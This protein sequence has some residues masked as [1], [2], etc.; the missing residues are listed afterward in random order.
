M[1]QYCS[2][3][4]LDEYENQ[5]CQNI[6]L[7]LGMD[8]AEHAFQKR[9]HE[10]SIQKLELQANVLNQLSNTQKNITSEELLLGIQSMI[11]LKNYWEQQHNDSLEVIQG[12]ESD[13]RDQTES[14]KTDCQDL[15]RLEREV[16]NY[17]N[18]IKTLTKNLTQEKWY[19]HGLRI[20]ILLIGW[21]TLIY[22]SGGSTTLWDIVS[23]TLV[24]MLCSVYFSPIRNKIQ[25][26]KLRVNKPKKSGDRL[27]KRIVRFYSKYEMSKLQDPDFPK[28]IATRYHTP[29]LEH[30]LFKTLVS[31]YGP[32][33]I[34]PNEL[35]VNESNKV[36]QLVGLTG[37]I[38]VGFVSYFIYTYF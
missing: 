1:A 20:S 10:L 3:I 7:Q 6:H 17:S 22:K 35:L 27:T 28:R 13:L 33:P 21:S 15:D 12:L 38:L 5:K 26:L 16:T 4:T 24:A 19:N 25:E 34:E 14:L 29:E 30:A 2:K 32:E 9:T 37:S 11:Q 31:K 8:L 23:T 36:Y 18:E